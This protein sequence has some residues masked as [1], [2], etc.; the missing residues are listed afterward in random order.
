MVAEFED[1]PI[2]CADTITEANA[3][4]PILR[5]SAVYI[6]TSAATTEEISSDQDMRELLSRAMLKRGGELLRSVERLIKGKPISPTEESI[7]L[8]AEETKLTS[9]PKTTAVL[10]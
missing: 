1:V 7:N 4:R 6:R 2:I 5:K 9:P 10:N 3:S 8:Y